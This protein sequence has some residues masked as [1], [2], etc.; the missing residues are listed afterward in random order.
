MGSS[1]GAGPSGSVPTPMP[2]AFAGGST[3]SGAGISGSKSGHHDDGD[4]LSSAAPYPASPT[5]KEKTPAVHA[6]CS[7]RSSNSSTNTNLVVD[8]TPYNGTEPV[9]EVAGSEM[10]PNP[11][12]GAYVSDSDFSSGD[13]AGADNTTE[14]Y[15]SVSSEH[16]SGELASNSSDESSGDEEYNSSDESS[17]DEASDSSDEGS[18]EDETDHSRS[19]EQNSRNSSSDLSSDSE[20]SQSNLLLERKRKHVVAA[21]SA[22]ISPPKCS[23]SAV[24]EYFTSTPLARGERV[25]FLARVNS[26]KGN[27]AIDVKGS[28]RSSTDRSHNWVIGT[29]TIRTPILKFKHSALFNT[30]PI[31]LVNFFLSFITSLLIGFGSCNLLSFFY[32]LIHVACSNILCP[33]NEA[34]YKLFFNVPCLFLLFQFPCRK[35]CSVVQVAAMGLGH[36]CWNFTLVAMRE[37]FILR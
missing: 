14:T 24:K 6:S 29:D 26:N 9:E 27:V 10:A 28:D 30:V 22:S 4:G 11:G 19:S 16:S 31:F 34:S 33:L 23:R 18:A 36:G 8:S 17:G 32:Y 37:Q 12:G 13:E 21:T 25:G 15:Y 7:S 20:S 3:S 5:V 35:I 2:F 1:F